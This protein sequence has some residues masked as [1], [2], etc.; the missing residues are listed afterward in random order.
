MAS[1]APLLALLCTCAC[2]A[3][4]MAISRFVSRINCE[5]FRVRPHILYLTQDFF[6]VVL[7]LSPST[8]IPQVLPPFRLDGLLQTTT[9]AI[10][11]VNGRRTSTR[12]TSRGGL[13]PPIS[14][15]PLAQPQRAR[16]VRSSATQGS[17]TRPVERNLR[18]GSASLV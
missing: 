1:Q 12:P 18:A 16:F 2:V 6:C 7:V 8:S 11:G 4:R 14:S 5:P 15:V 3:S 17:A 10:S 9:T 13:S